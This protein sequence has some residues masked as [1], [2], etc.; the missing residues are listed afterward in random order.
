[1]KDLLRI[2]V[3]LLVWLAA[4]SAIYGLQ[5]LGCASQL[6][7]ETFAGISLLRVVLVGAWGLTIALQSGM[8]LWIERTSP[9][10]DWTHKVS[11]VTAWTALLA[12]L[13][14][15]FPV[16]VMSACG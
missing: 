7:R 16:A 15:L 4:F 9:V 13:W 6:D 2:L 12:A 1:M 14:S 8:V 3:P 11:R 10:L 5:G